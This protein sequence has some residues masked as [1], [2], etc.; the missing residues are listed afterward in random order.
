MSKATK[1]IQQALGYQPT[2]ASWFA[3]TKLLFN[4]V[5]AF[6]FDVVTAHPGLLDLDAQAALTALERLTHVTKDNPHPLMPLSAI[7]GNIPAMF[8]R[9]AIHAAL[10]SAHSFATHLDQ[11]RRRKE[12]ASEKGKKF[13]QSPPVP[14]RSWNKS[15]VLYAGQWKDRASKSI[16]LKLWTGSSWCWVKCRVSGRE[17]PHGWEA[18]S[19]H[20]VQH[21][22][23]W[24][25]HTPIEQ[26][27]PSP[28]KVQ[29]Q[30]TTNQD[31][32][33]CA[34]DMNLDT[35]IAVCT[36]QTV[37]GTVLSTRFIGE[38]KETHGLRKRLLGRIARKRG[39]TGI[40]AEGEQDNVRLWAKVRHLDEQLAHQISHRI[41]AFAHAYDARILVFEHLGS[42]R[43]EKGKYSRRTNSKRSYWL[44]GRIFAYSKYKAWNAGGIITSRVSPRN[45]SRDC[46]RCGAPLARYHAG[47]PA[48]RYSPGAPLVLCVHCGM[49][50]HA[51]RN[52]SIVIGKRLIS[53][54][55][56][57]RQEKPHAP[58]Y[59]ERPAK[60]GG[61]A[62][63][64]DAQREGRPSTNRARHGTSNEQGAAQGEA[65]RMGETSPGIPHPLRPLG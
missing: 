29:T 59:A 12:Q 56:N 52:A 26:Q 51:D 21:G 6:Y 63:S 15:P 62:G 45:T 46:A 37:E 65:S 40:L 23:H 47:Q 64:Q 5:T 41:V 18:G 36:I 9:A 42:L 20:L 61:V 60:A 2:Q 38:G 17:I 24:W 32:K 39:K 28:G 48:E 22:M 54:Y 44:K 19:P 34:V 1:T 50:G 31:L 11:W 10:G 8:R 55:Q 49:K 33:I 13:T 25:I 30:V 35:H 58:L 27:M 57:Q 53:R 14:P 3:V 43:P 16:L 7:A 4:Q